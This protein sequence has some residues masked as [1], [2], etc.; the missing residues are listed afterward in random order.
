[1]V[2]GIG[3]D[4]LEID[5]F[6]KSVDR[7]G[8]RLLNRVFTAAEIDYCTGKFNAYQH[9]AARFAAKE[10]FSKAMATGLRGSFSWKDVEVVNDRLGRPGFNLH[11]P[12]DGQFNGSSVFLSMSHSESH[13]VA[14]VVLEES[15]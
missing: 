10:A 15:E 5:R 14:M 6:Q 12:L 7:F 9:F 1:M 11:G 3:V 8:S 13:V 2:K 4:I